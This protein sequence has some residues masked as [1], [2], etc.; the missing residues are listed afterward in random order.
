MLLSTPTLK[1]QSMQL[2]HYGKQCFIDVLNKRKNCP[3]CFNSYHFRYQAKDK[4]SWTESLQAFPHINLFLIFHAC[5][6]HF[7]C[8]FS[9]VCLLWFCPL[10]L[11]TTP[12][13]LTYKKS[14]CFLNRIFKPS[15]SQWPCGVRR[16]SSAARM[17][18]L[19][20]RIT[21]GA[22]M[23]FCCECYVLSSGGLCD[24]LITR[25]EVSDCVSS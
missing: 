1:I 20:V 12:N 19:W 6:C 4:W 13:I 11:I 14:F 17:L 15:R 25:P 24:E 7:P 8:T 23:F 18:R 5:N 21:P 22:W 9:A 2:P 10:L 3:L 16:R